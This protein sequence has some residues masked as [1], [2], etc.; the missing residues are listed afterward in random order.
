MSRR[1]RRGGF[2]TGSEDTTVLEGGT[3][4]GSLLAPEDRVFGGD[5]DQAE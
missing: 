4:Q 1:D 5:H 3:P 2:N